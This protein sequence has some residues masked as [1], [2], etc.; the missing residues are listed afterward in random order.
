PLQQLHPLGQ[1]IT[2]GRERNIVGGAEGGE[3]PAV[4]VLVRQQQLQLRTLH[5][6]LGGAVGRGHQAVGD[7]DRG[8]ELALAEQRVDGRLVDVQQVR[9]EDAVLVVLCAPGRSPP[10]GTAP[11]ARGTEWRTS[12]SSS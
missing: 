8:G 12:A 9:V 10:A 1:L 2:L 3:Q 11:P 4:G 7:T 5:L 6:L